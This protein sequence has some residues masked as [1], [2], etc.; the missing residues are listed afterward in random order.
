METYYALQSSKS[1]ALTA[2][3]QWIAHPGCNLDRGP[4]SLVTFRA[5]YSF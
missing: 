4:V 3:W 1:L 5:H 2:G